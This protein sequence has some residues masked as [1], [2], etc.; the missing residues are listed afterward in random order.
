MP[1]TFLKKSGLVQYHSRCASGFSLR[2]YAPDTSLKSVTA[3][4]V[5][6]HCCRLKPRNS[7]LSIEPSA[8]I[9]SVC[10][11]PRRLCAAYREI[12]LKPFTTI[13]APAT[14]PT[15]VIEDIMTIPPICIRN[16]YTY[17]VH[18]P[19]LR[20]CTHPVRDYHSGYPSNILQ[21]GREINESRI[22]F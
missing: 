8:N 16:P 10:L 18:L 17:A 22:N 15:G 13:T 20:I 3:L 19:I 12:V 9:P 14:T 11:S 5:P 4:Y 7:A 21:L 2:S 1:D 6:S